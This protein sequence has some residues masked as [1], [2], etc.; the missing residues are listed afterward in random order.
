MIILGCKKEV[1]VYNND[2]STNLNLPLLLRFNGKDCFFD[3]ES[4]VL[5]YSL[6]EPSSMDF[7]PLVAFGP[8]TA[9]NFNGVDLINNSAN[10][11][12]NITLNNPYDISFTFSNQTKDFK[13]FFVAIP[14]IRIV[15]NSEIVNTPK[16]PAKITM[17]YP[18]LATPSKTH[19]IGIENRG[20]TSLQFDKK[21]FG[22]SFVR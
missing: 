12:G 4:D 17:N 14:Q 6:D 8:N 11:L 1:I 9:V 18:G 16:I 7:S 2:A 10:N 22:F 21:S 13:L 19:W 15:T 20:K 5:K 3:S